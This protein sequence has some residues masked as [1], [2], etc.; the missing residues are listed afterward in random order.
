MCYKKTFENER[1]FE[2]LK[3]FQTIMTRYNKVFTRLR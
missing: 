2:D 1:E 3:I